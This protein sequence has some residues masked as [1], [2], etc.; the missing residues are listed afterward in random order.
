MTDSEREFLTTVVREESECWHRRK[1]PESF[2]RTVVG[3]RMLCRLHGLQ[4]V[5]LIANG[6]S[7]PR[8]WQECGCSRTNE[9]KETK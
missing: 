9:M 3:K 2:P 7:V 1:R 8:C 5:V 4:R 6:Y